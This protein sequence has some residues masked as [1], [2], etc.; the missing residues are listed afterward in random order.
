MDAVAER[1][2]HVLVQID[3]GDSGPFAQARGVVVNTRLGTV[4]EPSLVASILARGYW[5]PF[6]GDPQ[7]IL[8]LVQQ[9]FTAAGFDPAKHPRYPK[10]REDG[11]RFAPKA[12]AA[13]PWE[14]FRISNPRTAFE[15]MGI[16][17]G[18]LSE[19]QL[20]TLR[21]QL[22]AKV[23]E[24]RS[25]REFLRK[26]R[27]VPVLTRGRWMPPSDPV[28]P[29][30]L[31]AARAW[32]AYQYLKSGL[33]AAGFDE[34]KHK[35]HPKGT[36]VRGKEGGGRFAPKE[37]AEQSDREYD[38]SRLRDEGEYE[39]EGLSGTP[40]WLGTNALT[41]E[42]AY[43]KA[44][45]P[46]EA[47]AI[48]RAWLEEE[49]ITESAQGV[50]LADLNNVGVVALME[51]H[52]PD[53]YEFFLSINDLH[54]ED[55]RRNYLQ[56]GEYVPERAAYHNGIRA[57]FLEH[58]QLPQDGEPPMALFMA[59][60]SGAGKSSILGKQVDGLWQDSLIEGVPD[61]SVYVN[62]DDIKE[63]LPE[64]QVL[65]DRDDMRW[66]ALAHEESSDIAAR[67]R[68]DAE[69]VGFPMVIDGTGDA[70]P[71][72]FLGKIQDAE[73][74]GYRT[75]VVFVDIPTEEAIRRAEERAARTKRKVS[76]EA[77]RDIH[78]NVTQRHLEWRDEVDNWEVWANDDEADG[79]R[80]LIARRI[81]GGKIE[82]IDEPRYA[83]MAEKAKE[84]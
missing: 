37:L 9:G 42:D 78:R 54:K 22:V 30:D 18:M 2:N 80:R 8:T 34:T 76:R 45:R 71:G 84:S 46:R 35:R 40:S 38:R 51:Q 70:A 23:G 28:G 10:G 29:E 27:A 39:S 83:Q 6:S 61:H 26:F 72:K 68:K 58:A 13:S 15:A 55:F 17:H 59:G 75:K 31:G 77:I 66:A 62:P 44:T 12:G 14:A 64:A 3:E 81:N 53:G 20:E 1:G 36:P 25:Q 11:G 63:M 32:A 43:Y 56:N 65:R 73:K 69:Q 5:T 82:Y 67:L 7:P 16:E 24:P 4:S 47:V 49:G 33:T 52:Y 41:P 74:A 21:A 48:A 19:A 57:K 79:G 60:G 50:P